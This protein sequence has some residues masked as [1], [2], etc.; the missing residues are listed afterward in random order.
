[1]NASLEIKKF[2]QGGWQWQLPDAGFLTP[3]LENLPEQLRQ[4][5]VKQN[6]LRTVFKASSDNGELFVKYDHPRSALNKLKARFKTKVRQEFEAAKLLESAGIPVV[7]Y[8]GWGVRGIEGMLISRALNNSINARNY[9]F[10]NAIPEPDKRIKF[11]NG[12][13]A[14]I[15]TFT[16]NNFYHPDFHLGNLLYC[17]D[18]GEFRIVDPY[19]IR[20]TGGLSSA[21]QF[22]MQQ[23]AG[24]MRGELTE[25]EIVDLY[26]NSGWAKKRE[27][28]L[29][30]W[31]KIV[32]ASNANMEKLWPK[33]RGQILSGK[34]KYC[35][36]VVTP[37]G[38]A[39]M[40]RKDISGKL[41]IVP[42]KIREV[43]QNLSCREMSISEAEEIWLDSFRKQF[44]REPADSLPVLWE[45]N[46]GKIYS[47]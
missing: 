27:P 37:G 32:A 25:Q 34:S 28:A 41:M 19:G 20:K 5:L 8:P 39:F 24:A 3:W 35:E 29:A 38:N 15:K 43:L 30:I 46:S 6:A 21:Q 33:R 22:K 23:I 2:E 1:M 36:K 42:E 4:N 14:F 9:W 11:L 7:E 10:E 13:T 16:T 18:T 45:I 40:I 31:K 12:L 17:P 47:E 26:V 44:R